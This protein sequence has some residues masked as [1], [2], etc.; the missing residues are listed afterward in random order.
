MVA[1]SNFT[2]EQLAAHSGLAR[3]RIDVIPV[4]IDDSFTPSPARE[5]GAAPVVLCFGGTPNKNLGRIVDALTGTAF[6]LNVV[7]RL[8][9]AA[10]ARLEDSGLSW[11]NR[12]GLTD[13]E[14]ARWYAD[15]DVVLFP[16]TYEGFGMP[17]VE[18]QATGRPVVTSDRAPMND[19]AGGAACMVDPEDPASIRAGVERVLA[20]DGYRADLVRRGFNNRERFRPEVAARAYAQIYREMAEGISATT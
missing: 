9:D 8:D 12:T 20:D 6:H 15:S 14:L 13:D 5:P 1:I 2:A 3:E 7:G 17:I 10:T 4:T 18:A 19:V 11:T 16:S